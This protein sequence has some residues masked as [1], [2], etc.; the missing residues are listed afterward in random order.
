MLSAVCRAARLRAFH[1][2]LQPEL[3]Q[4][5]DIHPLSLH[6][7]VRASLACDVGTT[8]R[9]PV[10]RYDWTASS[11]SDFYGSGCLAFSTGIA[12]RVLGGGDTGGLGACRPHFLSR[13]RLRP[14][15]PHVQPSCRLL[16][17]LGNLGDGGATTTGSALYRA[18]RLAGGDHAADALIAFGVLW[19]TLVAP[20]SLR[21]GLSLRLPATPIDVVL[22]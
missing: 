13:R 6:G 14:L 10:A 5:A 11:T 19:T 18:P 9:F 22:A 7:I 17:T 4:P 16:E 3:D 12:S 2:R 8:V 20:F 15:A 21:L 1:L